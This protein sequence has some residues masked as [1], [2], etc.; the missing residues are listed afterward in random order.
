M[1]P[2]SGIPPVNSLLPFSQLN[3]TNTVQD[4]PSVA[5][6]DGAY[7]AGSDFSQFLTEAL[8]Q[9]DALQKNA[10]T[11]SIALATGQVQDLHTVMVALEKASLSLALTVEVRNKALDAYHEMMRMQI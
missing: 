11:A 8:K 6:G 4:S 10:E 1:S 2:V 7:K 5:S 3:S 9:V